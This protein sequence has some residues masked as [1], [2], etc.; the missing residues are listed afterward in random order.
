MRKVIVG[1]GAMLVLGGCEAL[2]PVAAT[3]GMQAATIG[4]QGFL[5]RIQE[6]ST[7]AMLWREAHRDIMQDV[8]RGC[9]DAAKAE[10]EWAKKLPI[11]KECLTLS[12]DNQPS[13]LIEDIAMRLDERRARREAAQVRADQ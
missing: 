8:L 12:L 3:I 11:L 13:L 1:L 10:A 9:G 5:S 7:Q 4:G 2:L 6:D